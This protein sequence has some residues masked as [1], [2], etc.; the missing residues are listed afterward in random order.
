MTEFKRTQFFGLPE[1]RAD[2]KKTRLIKMP[3]KSLFRA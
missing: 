2:A 1:E 3:A